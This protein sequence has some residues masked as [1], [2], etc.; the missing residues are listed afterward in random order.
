MMNFCT[1]FS[2]IQSIVRFID[3]VQLILI[4]LFKKASGM[5][6]KICVPIK[7]NVDGNKKQSEC[8]FNYVHFSYFAYT[9][10]FS[11]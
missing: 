4:A 3:L 2:V 10:F 5:S 9:F 8:I 7:Y 1:L 6:I 11:F